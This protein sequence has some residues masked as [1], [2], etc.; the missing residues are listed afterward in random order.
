MFTGIVEAVGK[1]IDSTEN[2]NILRLSIECPKTWELAVGQSIAVNGVCL[3][4]VKHSEGAFEVEMMTETRTRSSFDTSTPTAVNLERAMAANGRF[5]GHV[6]QGHIDAVG[7]VS[8]IKAGERTKDITIS[9][10]PDYAHLVVPKGSIAIDGVSLTVTNPAPD[11]CTV[12]LIPH[13]LASTILGD[14]KEGGLV[15]I[16]FDILGKYLIKKFI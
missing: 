6:V 3:T 11:E 2:E 7:K 1:V 14:L 4:V 5:E 16:E 13:T 15:N 9:Y 8:K 12:C 10:S